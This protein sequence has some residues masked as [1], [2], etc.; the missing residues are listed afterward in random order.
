MF[1]RTPTVERWLQDILDDVDRNATARDVH[2]IK[3]AE[4]PVYVG[5][6]VSHT[7]TT[8]TLKLWGTNAVA[9]F[10]YSKLEY[11]LAYDNDTGYMV[12]AELG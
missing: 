1:E 8:V 12:E 10:E 7:D 3:L 4:G 5:V 2:Q 6:Y 11:M 9:T